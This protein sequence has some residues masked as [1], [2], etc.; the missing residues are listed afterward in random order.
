MIAFSPLLVVLLITI[1]F[2]IHS[3]Y[4]NILLIFL[5]LRKF[6]VSIEFS[7]EK[8]VGGI[9]FIIPKGEGSFA[10]VGQYY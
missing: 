9:Q 2:E 6:R 7:V 4:W 5:E 3:I 1:Q 8:P 10:E